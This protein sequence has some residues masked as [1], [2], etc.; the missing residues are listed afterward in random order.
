MST[1]APTVVRVAVPKPLRTLFDY[2]VPPGEP[3]PAP[4]A[5][6]RVPFGSAD[7]VGVCVE[8]GATPDAALALKSIRN[9][10]D[11]TP[12]LPPALLALIGWA[13]A[14]YHH[15]IG[16]AVFTALPA[17]L[18]DG[19]PI[20]DLYETV[21]RVCDADAA[22]IGRA[23][24]Q[25]ALLDFIVARGGSAD[26]S[27]LAANG[28]D[29]RIVRALAARGAIDSAPRLPTHSAATSDTALAPNPEQRLAC[30]VIKA[31]LDRFAPTLLHG[32]TGSGKTEVYLNAI[33]AVLAAGR[34]ALVLVPEIALT[35]Q[36]VQRFRARFGAAE[37]YHS[38]LPDRERAQV[39][40]A[41][42][43]GRA[44]V[45]IGTRSAVFVPF[46]ALGIIVVDEE[47]DGSFKQQ[48]GFRY[49]ARD[50]A[51]MRAR[52]ARIPIVLGSATPALETLFNARAGRYR[53][54]ELPRRTGSAAAPRM[55]IVDVRGLTLREGLSEPLLRALKQHLDAGHQA[56]FFINRRGYAPSYICTACGWRATCSHC[57]MR[58]T[59]HRFPPRLRCHHC[60][61]EE[62]VPVACPSCARDALLPLGFGTQRTAQAL[63]AEFPDVPIVRIDRDTTRTEA[64]LVAHLQQIARGE[65]AIL[66]GTQMLAKGHHFPRVTLVAI[67]NA[68][69]GF[70]SADFRAP[71][72]TAQLIEQVAGRAGRADHPGQVLIQSFD[73]AHPLLT[74]LV[75]HGYRGFADA[76]LTHREAAGLPPFR[77][78]A[79]LRAEGPTIEAAM[80]CIASLTESVP[81]TDGVELW[82]PAPAPMVRKADRLRA[83][84]VVIANDRRR[85]ASALERIVAAG[86]NVGRRTR[87]SLDVDPYDM[88]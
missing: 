1:S 81:G 48:D 3:P 74:A 84:A 8:H 65:R 27:V 5:R 35:P 43:T 86:A 36:T 20:D 46:P 75:E 67:L 49:S 52:D 44:S 14:Y 30:D 50:L 10:I 15:P 24:R 18:R 29:A 69:L 72:H 70:A 87:W 40:E 45:L 47:H 59:L 32:V 21:Y 85:L 25:R 56:L 12:L 78:L 39:W 23:K 13:S 16:D 4:G 71:E 33:E 54:L 68:D 88:V 31:S 76:E 83:Q 37:V 41:C 2:A 77:P 42:R 64:K 34:Q 80:S 9:T 6:V 28:F 66:V 53:R 63:A 61:R 57:D 62:P 51:V 38:A 22:G 73:P 82:G 79:L 60:G 7:V 11:A 19:R 58:F 17:W 55:Q 26:A